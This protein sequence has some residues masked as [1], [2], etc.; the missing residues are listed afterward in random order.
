MTRSILAA[1]VAAAA[2]TFA[3][4]AIEVPAVNNA[5]VQPA[6]PRTG[7][8]GKRF[9]NIEGSSY[10]NFASFG[11]LDFDVSSQIDP[12]SI[13]SLSLTLIESNAAFTTAGLLDFYISTDTATS[14]EPGG[15]L[16]FD[17]TDTP[18]GL[19][20]Q[21]QPLHLLGQGAF[22]TTG[23]TNTGQVDV[24][25]FAIADGPLKDYL[26]EQIGTGNIRIV[27]AAA[28]ETVAATFTGYTNTTLPTPS[29]RIVEVP[30]PATLGVVAAGA[31]ALLRRR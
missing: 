19:G 16:V 25:T 15:G 4:A 17:T 6:G 13:G 27:V 30:E 8:N 28:D 11:V 10:G 29:L 31:I 3:S 24:Y 9:L 5:T 21:L 12:A 26:F 2:T 18:D 20:T 1:V 14:I 23:N 22:T 7:A